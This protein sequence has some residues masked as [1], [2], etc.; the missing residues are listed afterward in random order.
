MITVTVSAILMVVMS[1]K[2]NL[3]AQYNG[4]VS[5]MEVPIKMFLLF[6]FWLLIDETYLDNLFTRLQIIVHIDISGN[7]HLSGTIPFD[8]LEKNSTTYLFIFFTFLII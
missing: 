2:N 1:V 5:N 4:R 8:I 3:A 6:F 7:K